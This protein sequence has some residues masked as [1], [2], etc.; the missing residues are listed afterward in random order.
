MGANFVALAGYFAGIAGCILL[1]AGTSRLMSI[2]CAGA[3]AVW[4]DPT[5]RARRILSPKKNRRPLKPAEVLVAICKNPPHLVQINR[6][7]DLRLQLLEIREHILRARRIVEEQRSRMGRLR[8]RGHS[9]KLH[10]HLF[11][12]FERSLAHMEKYE[13][14]LAIE[15]EDERRQQLHV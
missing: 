1:G 2:W 11:Q 7:V 3:A 6:E 4:E 14:M 9:M 8:T 13:R 12:L 5:P 15:I 10:E